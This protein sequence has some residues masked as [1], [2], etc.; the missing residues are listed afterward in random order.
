MPYNPRG[1]GGVGEGWGHP[2]PQLPLPQSP[3]LL[4]GFCTA[5][6]ALV[7]SILHPRPINFKFYKHSVK[8]VAAL[9]VLGEWPPAAHFASGPRS[10]VPS[11]AEPLAVSSALLG[12]IYSIF[13]LHRNHVSLGGRAGAA[14]GGPGPTRPGPW[15]SQCPPPGASG[16]DRDP[17]SGPGDG[18]SAARPAC[19]HDCVH[20]LRPEPAAEPGRLLHPPDAHQPGGQAPAGV[21]RQG[22]GR[23]VGDT[24]GPPHPHPSL[25]N[26]D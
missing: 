14:T 3:H 4:P 8:F 7:S 20:A 10:P 16:R 22:G 1:V 25:S 26:V 18:G 17:G 2:D 11:P 13:I 5:K 9:S 15:H 12:T 6:G 21:F 24:A 19:R 23:G